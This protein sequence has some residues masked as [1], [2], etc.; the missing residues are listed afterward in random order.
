M[1]NKEFLETYPLYRKFRC[2]VPTGLLDVPVP[3]INLYCRICKSEQTYQMVYDYRY[4]DPRIGSYLSSEGKILRI[5]YKCA[6]CQK[7]EYIFLLRFDEN[8]QYMEKVGQYPPWSI[9]IEKSLAEIFGKYEETYKKGLINESQGYGIGAFAY[10]RRII[11]EI[12]DELLDSIPEI[13]GETEKAAYMD[14]LQKAKQEKD[15]TSKI[16]LIIDL[17]PD[18]LKPQGFNPFKVIHDQLS[19]GIHVDTDEE[20]LEKAAALRD[21]LIFLIN[22]IVRNRNA[23]RE[24]TASMKKLLDKKK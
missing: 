19:Q 16:D 7:Y 13:M 21:A 4:G 9:K 12:I 20:C 3:T 1:P 6:G 17:V 5:A 14:A 2:E 11:E 18:V 22:Q 8:L 15:A 10:Y 23:K 24:F